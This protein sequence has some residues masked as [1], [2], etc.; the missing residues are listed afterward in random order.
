MTQP[1]VLLAITVY[2]G[3]DVVERT[4]HSAAGLS[5]QM[6]DIDVLVLDDASPEPGLSED[7]A[8]W[9]AHHGH[10]YYRSPRNLGIPRNVNL[11][12]LAAM[13][14][15]YDHVIISNS[16]VVYGTN[17]VDELV[18]AAQSDARIGAVTSWSTN[19]SLYSI[20]NR[21]PERHLTVQ[22][23]TDTVA[24]ALASQFSG[25]VLDI[26][27]GISFSMLIPVPVVRT[28]GLMDPVFG[29]GY[30]EETDWSQRC[31]AAGYRLVL[32]LGSF[33]YHAG[34]GSTVDAGVLAAG[35]TT[36]PGNERIIDMRYP[37]FRTEVDAF[38]SSGA[39]QRLQH[40]ASTAVI[41]QCVERHGYGVS[42]GL[43]PPSREATIDAPA[44][45]DVVLDGDQAVVTVDALGFGD[46]MSGPAL[47]LAASVRQ[48][49][50][51]PVAV[52]LF[53]T[54]PWAWRTA[55]LLAAGGDVVQHR[56][57]PA[58]V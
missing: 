28:V 41:A 21:D 57:Y 53:D 46:T 54:G 37:E 40:R 5:H 23:N 18:R 14:G 20:P 34:G 8:R 19:V 33:V 16:D 49:F 51:D 32:G 22:T 3:R 15:N 29:R 42:V 27:A 12:L 50:G 10:R 43:R 36:V 31:L 11:G 39:L 25:Q 52:D 38:Y 13:E 24:H 44:I 58:R 7:V 56:N 6:A 47:D 48:R 2:N 9:C 55:E 45:V 1:R 35:S 30:C 26:P 4:L 17:A